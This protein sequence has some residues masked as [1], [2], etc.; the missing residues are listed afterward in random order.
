M[1]D[2]GQWRCGYNNL[3]KILIKSVAA[4]RVAATFVA[5]YTLLENSCFP[6]SSDYVT[7]REKSGPVRSQRKSAVPF[8]EKC[9]CTTNFRLSIL[10]SLRFTVE[11]EIGFSVTNTQ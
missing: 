1:K 4:K 10:L 5:G 8:L 3:G 11:F 9:F 2:P 6:T 7:Y